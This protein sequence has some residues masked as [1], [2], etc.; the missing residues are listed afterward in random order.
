MSAPLD[1][2]PARL[3]S[4]LSL[5]IAATVVSVLE[6]D[7]SMGVLAVVLG[8][9]VARAGAHRFRSDGRLHGS[10]ALSVGGGVGLA[11]I[12][13]ATSS[14]TDLA[15]LIEVGLGVAGIGC[16]GLA[17]LPM[18]AVGSRLFLKAGSA[19][20]LF[21]VLAGALF[22]SVSGAVAL[23]ACAGVVAAWDAAENAVTV[24][25]Q[26]G[27]EARTWTIEV[28]HLAGTGLVG[29]V[30]VGTGLVVKGV[31][32]DGLSLHSLALVLVG[33]VALTLALHD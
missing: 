23:A 10:A 8:L 20:V 3:S 29:A 30:S 2:R 16:L 27:D 5:G 1:R 17:T 21:A 28:T 6:P 13:L 26:L 32:V 24:G 25:E 7:S 19:S 31:G 22:G 4:F 18:R 9:V 11:G 33:V 12:A 15:G 14:T